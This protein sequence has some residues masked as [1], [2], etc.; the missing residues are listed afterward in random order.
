MAHPPVILAPKTKFHIFRRAEEVAQILGHPPGDK[1]KLGR[2]S[3]PDPCRDHM[4]S[5]VRKRPL[6]SLDPINPEDREFVT[7]VVT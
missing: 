6:A 7:W 1:L 3:I 4:E 2:N 5:A